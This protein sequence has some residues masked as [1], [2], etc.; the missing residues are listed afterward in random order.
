MTEGR[1][2]AHTGLLQLTTDA[3]IAS[4]M[5]YKLYVPP[6]AQRIREQPECRDSPGASISLTLAPS[7]E[8]LDRRVNNTYV[9]VVDSHLRVI[10][11]D[12]P[13][14]FCKRPSLRGWFATTGN[15][16]FRRVGAFLFD[17]ELSVRPGENTICVDRL[18]DLEAVQDM[19]STVSRAR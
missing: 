4:K 14:A 1:T 9:R 8:V 10:K 15:V 6:S 2:C 3:T 12:E 5:H 7:L 13:E 17:R 16:L 18:K 11:A 19:S